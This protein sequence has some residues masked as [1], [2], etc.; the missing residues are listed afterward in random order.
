[1]IADFDRMNRCRPRANVVA[2]INIHGRKR[3]GLTGHH[4]ILLLRL[5]G[6]VLDLIHGK[7]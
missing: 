6:T 7:K 2:R 3:Y 1:M 5:A 4:Q